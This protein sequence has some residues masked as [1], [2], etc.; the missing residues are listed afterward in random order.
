MDTGPAT[1]PMPGPTTGPP[2]RWG[3]E[4]DPAR[5]IPGARLSRRSGPRP[6]WAGWTKDR[7]GPAHSMTPGDARGAWADRGAS[8]SSTGGPCSPLVY[9]EG[10]AEGRRWGDTAAQSDIRDKHGYKRRVGKQ[11]SVERVGWAMRS[12]TSLA[13]ALHSQ[14]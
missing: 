6:S 5:T 3:K 4:K 13:K 1:G 2:S 7:D 14:G 11:I 8:R 12:K 10:M 9:A